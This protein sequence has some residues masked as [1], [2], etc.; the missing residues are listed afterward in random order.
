MC[1]IRIRCVGAN[2]SHLQVQSEKVPD[3]RADAW[4]R[5]LRY[6]AL[7]RKL[8]RLEIQDFELQLFQ[9]LVSRNHGET[10]LPYL[11]EFAFAGFGR[12]KG[13]GLTGLSI[14]ASPSVRTLEI[15]SYEFNYH[16]PQRLDCNMAPTISNTFPNLQHLTLAIQGATGVSADF[17]TSFAVLKQLRH[18]NAEQP[19]LITEPSHLQALISALPQLESLN[20]GIMWIG[21]PPGTPLAP[22]SGLER[23]SAPCLRR[24]VICGLWEDVALLPAW[25]QCPVLEELE[26]SMRPTA[27]P[28]TYVNCDTLCACVR[29]VAEPDFAPRLRRLV[30]DAPVSYQIR[31]NRTPEVVV[32]ERRSIADILGPLSALEHL[33][34]VRFTMVF[35]VKARLFTPCLSDDDMHAL[36]VALRHVRTISLQIEYPPDARPSPTP[37]LLSLAHFASLCPR[38]VSLSLPYVNTK[39]PLP[40]STRN[41]DSPPLCKTLRTLSLPNATPLIESETCRLAAFLCG[42]FPSLDAAVAVTRSKDVKV[43]AAYWCSPGRSLDQ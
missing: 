32:P 33:E 15:C 16:R 5:F 1:E 36:A 8:R 25:L 35:V 29:E 18:L 3:P 27:G 31:R 19:I 30:I 23:T 43:E 24:L 13:A 10:F 4:S 42:L 39:A 22:A 28:V 20:A 11:R 41:K 6:A 40:P 38:L 37:T 21:T 17:F 12:S 26:L 14:L 9:I 34:D 7:V 2:E